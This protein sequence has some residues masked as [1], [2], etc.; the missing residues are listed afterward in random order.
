M[1]P[2]TMLWTDLRILVVDTVKVWWRMFPQIA[3]IYLLGWL[4]FQIAL[5]VAAYTDDLNVWVTIAIFAFGFLTQLIPVV[6]IL[7]LVGWEL[8]I[9][10]MIPAEVDEQAERDTSTTRLHAVT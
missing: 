8:G 2:L 3:G 10:Q 7:R 5:K 9:R 4:G 6:L 1:N